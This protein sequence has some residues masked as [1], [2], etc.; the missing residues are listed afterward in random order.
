MVWQGAGHTDYS[1]GMR[2]V[3]LWR[4]VCGTSRMYLLFYFALSNATADGFK[5]SVDIQQETV[6]GPVS[7]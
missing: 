6:V 2:E 1:G 7:L 5:Q 3:R 4:Y